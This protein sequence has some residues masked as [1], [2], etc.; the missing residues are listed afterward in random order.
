MIKKTG[1]AIVITIIFGCVLLGQAW[2]AS[3]KTIELKFA[4]PFSPKHTMQRV[5]FEPWAK[6]IEELTKGQIKVK[7]FPGG[8]LGK[9][10]D[11]Y[12]LAEKGIAD[13]IYTLNDYTPG[14]FPLTAVFELPFMGDTA[15]GFA[16]AMWK[17]YEK[18][19]EMQKE[20]AAVKT[21]AL[22]AH[23]AGS[24]FTL[25]KPI[26]KINDFKGMKIR[27]ANPFVT[28]ALKEFGA[29]PVS[30][31]VTEAYTALERGVVDG[32]VLPYEGI[33]VFK[34]A[35]L[36]KYVTEKT[37]FYTMTMT[38]VMNKKKW[39]SLPEDIK[40]II[41]ENSG[42]AM[43][44]ACGKAYDAVE[45]VLRGKCLEKGVKP[46][47]LPPEEYEKLAALSDP[48]RAQW[49]KDMKA[50]GLPGQAVLDE[51]IKLLK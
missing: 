32:T 46:F 13:I 28:K 40:K 51:A 30:M 22:W 39:E 5:V 44:L 43:S 29:A 45:G 11:H 20:Y 34:M 41:D 37:K 38:V 15:T 21:L 24:F 36:V 9:A 33:W 35:D 42:M 6:K 12:A 2:T 7:F 47:V 1:L 18:F 10:P 14:R 27:T 25:K 8:A 23:P 31:P 16:E 26:K 3:A 4:T 19:P 48:I 50:K 17:T 49:V